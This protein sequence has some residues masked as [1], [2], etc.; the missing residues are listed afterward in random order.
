MLICKFCDK[1]C[2][3]SNSLRNHERLC[4][5]NPD[6]QTTNLENYNN[7]PDSKRSNGYIKA[8]EHGKEY[9]L[10]DFSRSKISKYASSRTKDWH[11]ENGKKISS[12]INR[13]VSEGTWHTSLA[14][15]MHYELDGVD[16]HGS[17]ELEYVKYLNS[18]NVKW[19]RCKETFDYIFENKKRKYTPDFYLPEMDAFVEIKGYKTSKDVVK[20]DQFP[21]D[22]TLIVLQKKELLDIGL[23]IK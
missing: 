21:K 14:R 23:K 12:T 22:K 6:H 4:K 2:K 10:S 8:R 5:Y 17:W 15:K 16:L 9:S 1:E 3:N 7:N 11:K 20:W 13:K 19:I 18:I